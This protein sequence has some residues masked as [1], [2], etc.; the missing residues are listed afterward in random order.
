[1]KEKSRG[2]S[3]WVAFAMRVRPLPDCSVAG[4]HSHCGGVT[5]M[6]LSFRGVAQS[7]AFV[8]AHPL[9]VRPTNHLDV[10]GHPLDIISAFHDLSVSWLPHGVVSM[11]DGR[12]AWWRQATTIPC[13]STWSKS[14]A[15]RCLSVL[16][17]VVLLEVRLGSTSLTHSAT[18]PPCT[19]ISASDRFPVST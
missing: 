19:N 18:Q 4:R 15:S 8:A 13:R 1:M 11:V 17:V 9:L 12:P 6:G 14:S 16:A 5:R 3:R 10:P 2:L 7:H